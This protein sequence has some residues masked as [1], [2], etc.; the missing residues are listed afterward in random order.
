MQKAQVLKAIIEQ[1][2]KDLETQVQAAKDAHDAATHAES[3]A[4]TKWDTFGLESSYLAQGQQKR[5]EE[6]SQTLAYFKQLSKLPPGQSQFIQSN[7]LVLLEDDERQLYFYLAA[8]G[9]GVKV[10]LAEQDIIVV[11]IQTPIGKKLLDKNEGD[12]VHIMLKGKETEFEVVE[13]Y[14]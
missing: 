11:T 8:K 14:Q 9:G 10:K 7:C 2:E 12:I 3:V 5:V 13:I 1:L 6:I 4:Q